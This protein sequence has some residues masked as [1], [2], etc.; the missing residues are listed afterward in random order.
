MTAANNINEEEVGGNAIINTQHN[1]DEWH[2]GSKER[3][4]KHIVIAAKLGHDS[5][6]KVL[7]EYVYA[8]GFISKEEFAEVLHVRIKLLWMQ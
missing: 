6:V 8:A 3:G 7:R 4:T 5:A 2:Y 1:S